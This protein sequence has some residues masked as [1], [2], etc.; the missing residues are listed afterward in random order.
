LQAKGL[1]VRGSTAVADCIAVAARDAPFHP[2]R[3]FL[4]GLEWD[5]QPR[6]RIWLCDY[7]NATSGAQ[8]LAAVGTRFMV[9]A[10][11]RIMQPGCQADHSLVLE[12]AQGIG[13]TSAARA[14][15][16]RPEWFAGSLPD[17]HSKDAALQ[18]CGRWIIE[19]AE[20]KAIRSSQLEATKTFLTQ[21]VDTIRPPYGR[22]TAQ[23]PRQCVFLGTTNETEYLRDRSGN[24]RYWASALRASRH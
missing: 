7:L 24:R 23:F 22:R 18:L 16:V 9:S 10:V 4:D 11:A 13:K 6:L 8:Y 21:C 2:V 1:R 19:I 14:L 15:A 3:E 20:L 12:G 17:I 5:K